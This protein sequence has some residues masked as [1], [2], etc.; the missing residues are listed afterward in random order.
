VL[1]S[2]TTYDFTVSPL[3]SKIDP[4]QSTFR[5]TPHKI[6]ITLHKSTPG[7]KWS[8]LEGT[9]TISS[10]T[11]SSSALSPIPPLPKPETSPAYPTSS[12]TGPK[13]WDTLA[14]DA[15]KAEKKGGKESTGDD[16]EGEEIDGFFKQIYKNADPD[17]RRAMI[18]S[19][20]ESNGTALSTN[21]EDV[22]K[23]PVET[24]PPDGLEAKK[25]EG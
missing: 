18:K 21:W 9:E 5:I 3:F 20:Q 8:A 4:A 15:L 11:D 13:N 23:G 17:T 1:T 19:Y 6:E 7:L 25:W 22:K 16:D 10:S 12:R 24:Q 14:T 2:E